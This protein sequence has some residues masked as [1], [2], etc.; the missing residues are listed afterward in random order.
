MDVPLHSP[1]LNQRQKASLRATVL[2]LLL[3]VLVMGAFSIA[4]EH[5]GEN[6]LTQLTRWVQDQGALAPIAF[7]LINALGVILFIPQ[8]LFTIIAGMLFGPFEGVVHA[9]IGLTLGACACF[10]LARGAL[11]NPLKRRMGRHP[12]Y[13]KL[14]ALS[15]NHPIKVMALSRT[16]PVFPIPLLSYLWGLT[17]APF[18]PYL[19]TTAFCTIPETTFLTMGGHLLQTGV[20]GHNFSWGMVAGLAAVAVVLLVIV[21][22][23]R[24]MLA[25]EG[26][27][28]SS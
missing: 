11:R 18:A 10:F 16:V 5:V 20:T 4:L 12:A 24:S 6:H 7:I 3:L 2:K 8:V 9:T 15:R 23:A 26:A 1:H 19:L 25:K 14:E 17:P 22:K 27:E 28:S 13:H 21:T